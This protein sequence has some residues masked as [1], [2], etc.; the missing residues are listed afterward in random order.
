MPVR[1][2]VFLCC[3]V[4]SGCERKDS[5]DPVVVALAAEI[6]QRYL[7]GL[8]RKREGTRNL[9]RAIYHLEKASREGRDMAGLIEAAQR[10]NGDFGTGSE[11]FA[12]SVRG[13]SLRCAARNRISRITR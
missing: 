7:D 2:A 9:R 5:R 12:T 4:G 10:M 1:F 11:W 8:T 13:T 6:D 3:L